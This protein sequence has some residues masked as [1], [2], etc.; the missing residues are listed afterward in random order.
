MDTCSW[1][2]RA[3]TFTG[4]G[5]GEPDTSSMIRK[6]RDT[7]RM[8]SVGSASLPEFLTLTSMP[9]PAAA[10]NRPAGPGQQFSM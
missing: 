2:R 1:Q 7:L 8:R 4:S 6:A 5:R 9:C 3:M 10:G